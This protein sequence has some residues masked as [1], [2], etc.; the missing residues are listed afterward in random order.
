MSKT[1]E[2]SSMPESAAIDVGRVVDQQKIS[3]FNITL[4][5]LAA[6][7]SAVDGY[8]IFVPGYI[9]PELIKAWHVSPADLGS[10]F[11][12]GMIGIILGAPLFGWFG[13]RYGRKRAIVLGSLLYGAVSL[14]SLAA[15]TISQ[16][17]AMRFLIG[18]GIGGVIPNAL[19]LIAE[20]TPIRYRASFMMLVV[21]GV[22]IGQL[23]PGFV[24]AA[25]VPQYGWQVL[26]IVGGVGPILVAVLA[27]FGLP[28][29]IK[30][31]VLRTCRFGEVKRLVQ[32]M[33]P[34]ISLAKDARFIIPEPLIAAKIS[35]A[36][37][38][39]DGLALITPLVWIC[40]GAALVAIY[41]T[42]SWLPAALQA[43]GLTTQEAALRAVYFGAG[44]A[45]GALCFT[46]L[47]QRFGVVAVA[48]GFI[49]SVPLV[50]CIGISGLST[51][52]ISLL[53]ACAGF[54]IFGIINGM[55]SIMG[56]LYP[57]AIR[58]KGIGWGLGV[59]RLGSVAGPMVGGYFVGMK[60]T[61]FQLFLAPAAVLL[62]GAVLFCVLAVLCA[63]RFQGMQLNDEVAIHGATVM[64]AKPK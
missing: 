8:D 17:T 9:A 55:E 46:L 33:E 30:Y 29:S 27:Q 34:G 39:S 13:D 12:I 24:T 57:T 20:F 4:L 22:P 2:I 38:F 53:T 62:V 3:V 35:P 45:I 23:L 19:A 52:L 18:F 21:L 48:L 41:F 26:L 56:M 36:A 44:G 14:I 40:L 64:G 51:T 25:F 43:A 50:A 16:F 31:L 6:I 47:V 63:R 54:C 37:L 58:A 60:F 49:S 11:G 1:E 5:V 28:E 10:M 42:A 15:T 7:A 32:A 61:N 59:G